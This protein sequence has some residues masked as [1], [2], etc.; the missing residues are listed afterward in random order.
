MRASDHCADPRRMR[1]GRP[2]N[3]A[4]LAAGDAL[5]NG[6]LRVKITDFHDSTAADNLDSQHPMPN[7]RLR[8]RTEAE[9]LSRMLGP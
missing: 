6:A 5:F 4:G 9:K 2:K 3:Q 7:Q 8:I 1:N